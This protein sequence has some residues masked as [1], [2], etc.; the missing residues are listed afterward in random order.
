MPYTFVIG[1]S[2]IPRFIQDPLLGLQRGGSRLMV[3]G[4]QAV[5]S[6]GQGWAPVVPPGTD[7]RVRLTVVSVSVAR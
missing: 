4:A 5:N 2:E 3:V 7:V 1:G 6:S